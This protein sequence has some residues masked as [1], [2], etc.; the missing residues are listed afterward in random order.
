MTLV[1][2][3]SLAVTWYFID[4][5]T[6]A[7]RALFRRV[8]KEGAVVPALWKLE[9]ANVFQMA[10]RRKRISASFRDEALQDLA[11]VP[12]EIDSETQEHSWGATVGIADRYDLTIYDASYLELAQR[13]RLALATLD[14]KLIAA[15]SGAGVEVLP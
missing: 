11:F 10:L 12:I 9:M 6:D 8:G 14:G 13:R 15:A 7:T 3:A 4:E 5:Q 1:V 2:D